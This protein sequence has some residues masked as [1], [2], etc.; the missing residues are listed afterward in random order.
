MTAAVVELDPLSDPVGAAAEDD[1]LVAPV[2]IRLAGRLVGAVHVGRE[3]FE[4]G[5]AGVDA[6]VDR[7]DAVGHAPIAN[8][9]FAGVD[10]QRNLGIPESGALELSEPIGGELVEPAVRGGA[11]QRRDLFE[12]AQEPRID[13]RQLVDP[14]DRPA[15]R[16][17]AEDIPHPLIVRDGQPLAKRRVVLGP[18]TDDTPIGIR[19]REEQAAPAELQRP[20]AFH[21]RFLERPADRHHFPD[22][23][24]LRRQRPIGLG[25]LLEVPPRDLDHHVVDR[26]FEGGRR[27]ARDVVGNLVEVIAERQLGRDLGDRKTGRLRRQRRRARDA[28]VHFD[29][30]HPAGFRMHGEL[31]VRSAG[32]DADP[33]DDPAGGVAHAL[34]FLVAERENRRDGDAVAGVHPHRIDVLDRADDDEVVGGVA[35]HLELEFL[36]PDHRLLDQQLVNRAQ[37][38]APFDEI[39]ELLDVVGDA[40]ADAAERERRPDDQREAEGAR[41]IDRLRQRAGQAAVRHVEPDRTDR[42]LEQQAILGDLDRLDRGANQLDLKSVEHAGAGEIDGKIETG[43]SA[44]RREQRVGTLAL[45]DRFEHFDGERLDIGAIGQLGVG[46][47]RRRVAVDEDHLEPL[48]PQRLARLRS[49]IVELTGLADDD[50]ARADDEHALQV[51]SSWH[52]VGAERLESWVWRTC[53]GKPSPSPS[54]QPPL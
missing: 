43:L 44:D 52:D 38:Q 40:A 23:L 34:I 26:R 35:H 12:L 27:E 8:H 20:D 29:H 24:H 2:R 11:A 30:H 46:H 6:L 45:D 21:E 18:G 4:F 31:D 42:V 49:G 25:K 17:G 14:L 1:D 15:A 3:G 13:I 39:A 16:D 10:R 50:R 5:R 33:P 48:G 28:R 51:S 36:P 53:S 19:G 9:R 37:L 54:L 41:E 22:R 32:L 7:V 47:D